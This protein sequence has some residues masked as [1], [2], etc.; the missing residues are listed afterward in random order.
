MRAACLPRPCRSLNAAWGEPEGREKDVWIVGD[1]GTILRY[2]GVAFTAETVGPERLLGIWGSGSEPW[3][4]GEGQDVIYRRVGGVWQR[5]DPGFGAELQVVQG[6]PAYEGGQVWFA[7]KDGAVVRWSGSEFELMESGVSV[8]LTALLV[9]YEGTWIGG[10]EGTLLLWRKYGTGPELVH[11]V[12]APRATW[13]LLWTQ[14]Q[15]YYGTDDLT[16]LAEDGTL[17]LS[18]TS[19]GCYQE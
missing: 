1:A 6:G 17:L 18:S 14:H 16:L 2:D 3:V 10:Q 15:S 8:D 9:G 7:G 19:G 11:T 13:V 5:E 4:V 12:P